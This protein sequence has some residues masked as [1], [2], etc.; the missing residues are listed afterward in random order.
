MSIVGTIQAHWS[1]KGVNGE[2]FL[3][4][5][6]IIMFEQIQCEVIFKWN[7]NADFI[8][9]GSGVRF[10][11]ANAPIIPD[12]SFE[13]NIFSMVSMGTGFSEINKGPVF[14][15]LRSIG[16]QYIL[17]PSVS[18]SVHGP[19]S[20]R[21]YCPLPR[22]GDR[23]RMPSSTCPPWTVSFSLSLKLGFF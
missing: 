4:E 20:F 14:E 8:H 23:N 19:A 22:S 1:G 6:H 9:N 12:R 2:S 11:K 16:W 5:T 3:T 10:V 17:I 15:P 18:V 21:G 13:W 7:I